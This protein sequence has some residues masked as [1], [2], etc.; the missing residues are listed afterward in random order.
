MRNASIYITA[1]L[2]LLCMGTA[3]KLFP[4]PSSPAVA[5]EIADQEVAALNKAAPKFPRKPLLPADVMVVVNDTGGHGSGVFLG[6]NY[7]LTA[8]HVAPG[9]TAR[10]DLKF[11]DG[12]VRKA[13]LVWTS[14]D[15]DL[16]LL[17]ADGA[18]VEAA[19]LSC[20]DMAVGEVVTSRGNPFFL[21]FVRSF[22]KI[23]SPVYSKD[24]MPEQMK[25]LRYAQII[26]LTVL[27]GQ[28]G[29]P[30]F[31]EKGDLVGI[32]VAVVNAPGF[33]LTPTGFGIMVPGR[34]VCEALARPA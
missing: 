16:A 17:K 4:F 28:S 20:E 25:K 21:E 22:G 29:G 24:N 31:N 14:P 9:K 2:A 12:S 8:S 33:G 23:A 26:D 18:G 19:N 1:L 27:P 13:E 30:I 10:L 15:L 11:H 34:A 32:T 3:V 5:S 7:Y 6:G